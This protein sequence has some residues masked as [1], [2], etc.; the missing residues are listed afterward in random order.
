MPRSDDSLIRSD[1]IFRI[2]AW[3]LVGVA[4]LGLVRRIAPHLGSYV[5]DAYI[6]F[7]YAVHLADG[8]GLVW[9]IGGERVEGFT[10]PLHIWLLALG[11]R[12]GV[13]IT[14]WA[15]LLNFTSVAMCVLAFQTFLRRRVGGLPPIAAGLHR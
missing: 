5:E 3:L 2:A 8:H 9:N 11:V 1:R 14:H 12:L 6:S 4:L 7:R 13:P 15:S 10:S